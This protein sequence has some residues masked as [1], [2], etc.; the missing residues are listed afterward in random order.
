[1]V[2]FSLTVSAVQPWIYL[3]L[4]PAPAFVRMMSQLQGRRGEA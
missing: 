1:V 2:V 4:F 3:D